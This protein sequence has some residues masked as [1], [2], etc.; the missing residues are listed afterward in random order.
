MTKVSVMMPA[1]NAEKFISQALDSILLQDFQ[2]FQIVVSDDASTDGTADIVR[3]Y[4]EKYPDKI[5]AIYNSTNIGI[6]ANCN[7]ALS[8]CVGD[9][10]ALFAGDDIMLQGKLSRQVEL[11]DSTPKCVLCYHPVEIFDSDSNQTFFVTNKSYREDVYSTTDLLLKGGIPGGCSIMVRKSAIPTGGY[12]SR[13][14]TVSDWLFFLEISMSGELHKLD[15]VLARYRKHQAGASQLAYSLLSESLY[16][17][18]IFKEKYPNRTEL[19]EL[20][21][22]AKA[23][24]LAGEA[25]RKLE[26]DPILA[27][28]LATEVL[29]YKPASAK[30]RIL[31]FITLVIR[32]FPG[33][34]LLG[35][36]LLSFKYSLK[37]F[38]G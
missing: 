35:M 32:Y 9:Y 4:Q 34:K 10:V 33:G 38:L 11:M 16:A 5:T 2:D 37:R 21:P 27:L 24:Y 13:L 7:L 17:L 6:T 8:H 12:D 1:Y 19:L 15:L 31:Y 23:R 3:V 36:M 25:F 26:V 30:Y 20:L 28:R 29:V 22:Q 18:D 14:K